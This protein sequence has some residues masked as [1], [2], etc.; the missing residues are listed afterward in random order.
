MHAFLI[1]AHNEPLILQKLVSALD[2]VRN[3]IY[4]HWDKKSGEHPCLHT[5]YSNVFWTSKR[6]D[7]RWGNVSQIKSEYVLFEEAYNHKNYDYFHL[8]SG[9]HIPL[10]NQNDIHLFFELNNRYQILSAMDSSDFQIDLK[11]KRY[12]LFTRELHRGSKFRQLIFQRLWHLCI[13]A[14]RYLKISRHKN[15]S[16]KQASNWVSLTRDCVE[17]LLS[18]KNNILKHYKYTFCGDE[19]FVPTSLEHSAYK[20]NILYSDKILKCEM[21]KANPRIYE[22]RDYNDIMNS[23]CLFARKFSEKHIDVVDKI[24]SNYISE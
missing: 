16:Y 17:F 5:N 21:G 9:T 20:K 19:F 2:D 12:N 22:I 23:N 1:I 18:E 3:D 7:V 11:L 24:I 6:I 13:C 14:Q 15:I 4:I 10:K 8:I